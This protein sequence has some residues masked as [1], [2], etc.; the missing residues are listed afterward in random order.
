MKIL[1]NIMNIPKIKNKKELN[2][3]YSLHSGIV[4]QSLLK[5]FIIRN[6]NVPLLYINVQCITTVNTSCCYIGETIL[7][8]ADVIG[9]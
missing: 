7:F 6:N 5:M 8:K 3:S 4:S 2:S 1:Y 9:F